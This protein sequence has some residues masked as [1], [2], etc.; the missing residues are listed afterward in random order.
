MKIAEYISKFGTTI[1]T[2]AK[3]AGVHHHTVVS[4]LEEL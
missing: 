4:V 2:I 3:R 1:N